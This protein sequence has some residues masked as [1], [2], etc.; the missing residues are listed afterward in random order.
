M[1]VRHWIKVDDIVACNNPFFDMFSIHIDE[2][3]FDYDGKIM[4][5]PLAIQ[6]EVMSVKTGKGDAVVSAKTPGGLYVTFS[7]PP[8]RV[9]WP[10]PIPNNVVYLSDW[11]K[12]A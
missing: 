5:S 7:V 3:I 2:V 6:A 9:L 11:R 8:E 1:T 4:T 10:V 12:R